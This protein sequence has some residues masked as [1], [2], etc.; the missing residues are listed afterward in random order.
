MGL[1]VETPTGNSGSCRVSLSVTTRLPASRDTICIFSLPRLYMS[2]MFLGKDFSTYQETHKAAQMA[3]SGILLAMGPT[4]LS[5]EQLGKPKDPLQ[6]SPQATCGQPTQLP[7]KQVWRECV[8]VGEMQ[9]LS[10]GLM[11]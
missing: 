7:R 2:E 5:R 6:P 8:R 1:S 3:G 11:N 9:S 10:A 4:Q